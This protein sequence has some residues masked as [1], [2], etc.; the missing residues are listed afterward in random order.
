MEQEASEQSFET[1]LRQLC[2]LNC[3]EKH[4]HR[5][6]PSASHLISS[7]QR[8]TTHPEVA[9]P[10]PSMLLGT[11]SIFLRVF[12]ISLAAAA[13]CLLVF[14]AALDKL[15]LVLVLREGFSEP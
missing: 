12:P 5:F 11:A 4:L 3:H 6:R 9:V 1:A 7:G 13:H 15:A 2:I 8:K 14:E 10:E